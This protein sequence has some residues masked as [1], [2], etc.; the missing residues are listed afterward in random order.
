MKNKEKKIK[1]KHPRIQG[2]A[3]RR[4]DNTAKLFAAVS[5]ED[6]SSVFRISANLKEPV[7]QELLH[8]ALLLTLPEFENFRVT[9]RKGFFCY[10]FE[11]NDRDPV[12]E[13]EQIHIVRRDFRFV[14]ATTETA[15]I[16]RLSTG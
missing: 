11:T 16:L 13:K 14:S 5:G 9:L 1:K 10:Y 2:A 7:D 12:I 4:L 8:R 6:L 3:W 15:S